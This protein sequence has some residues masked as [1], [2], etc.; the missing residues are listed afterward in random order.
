MSV[1]PYD[2]L[3]F[4]TLRDPVALRENQRRL[5][6]A[7]GFDPASLY[8]VHQVHGP[9]LVVAEGDPARV[10]EQQADALVAEPSRGMPW[11]CVSP[12]ACRC[13]SPTRGPVVSR[14]CTRA[15][16]VWSRT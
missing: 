14:P 5:A 7:V 10:L 3:D 15:G 13:S 16:E 12:T 1:S 11:R 8:Q 6:A 9:A 2:S 4:A